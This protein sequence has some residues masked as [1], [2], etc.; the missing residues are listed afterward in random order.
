MYFRGVITS[1]LNDNFVKK[2]F[3]GRKIYYLEHFNISH[4]T[5]IEYKR[6]KIEQAHWLRKDC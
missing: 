3:T 6:I 4:L 1:T 2:Y 5:V